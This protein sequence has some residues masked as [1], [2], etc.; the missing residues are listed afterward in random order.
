MHRKMKKR[1][2]AGALSLILSIP[3]GATGI[4]AESSDRYTGGDG[5]SDLL[6]AFQFTVQQDVNFSSSGHTVGAIA[7]GGTL[8]LDNYFGDAAIVP[9]YVKNH[10]SGGFGN[11]WHGKYPERVTT[12]Y[13]GTTTQ[14]WPDSNTWICNADYM[15]LDAI[16]DAVRSESAALA[17][18]S[19][20]VTASNGVVNIDCTGDQDVYVSIDAQTFSS[21]LINIQLKEVNGQPNVDWFMTDIIRCR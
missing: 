3:A 9:S 21:S 11:A 4:A 7:V 15:D 12:V 16:F 8:K 6:S 20:A 14:Q 18:D 17:A 19:D 13:Y 5:I 2:L 1:M 10:E